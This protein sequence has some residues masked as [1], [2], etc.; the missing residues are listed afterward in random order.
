M[1]YPAEQCTDSYVRE[2]ARRYKE[3]ILDRSSR[4]KNSACLRHSKNIEHPSVNNDKFQILSSNH[5]NYKIRKIS[6]ALFVK[7]HRPSI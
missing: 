7:E 6:E 3:P 2:T 5:A 1:N 4:E